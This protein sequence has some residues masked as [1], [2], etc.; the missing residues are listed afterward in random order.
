[1]DGGWN[2]SSSSGE[3]EARPSASAATKSGWDFENESASCSSS[4]EAGLRAPNEPIDQEPETSKK[5]RGRPQGT[6]GSYALRSRL[7][8]IQ[9]DREK[10]EVEQKS[11]SL[12]VPGTAAWARHHKKLKFDQRQMEKHSFEQ[13]AKTL[14]DIG[15][16]SFGNR[17]QRLLCATLSQTLQL[18]HLGFGS[19]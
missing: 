6:K 12:P 7:K 9:A 18:D 4:N 16:P 14:V 1:M 5:K 8:D 2:F 3:D 19:G 15:A 10:K 11:A 13:G 17:M